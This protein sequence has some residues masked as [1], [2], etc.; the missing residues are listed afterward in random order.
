MPFN[1]ALTLREATKRRVGPHQT[2]FFFV[3]FAYVKEVFLK[4][5]P[6]YAYLEL[7]Y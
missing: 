5:E 7:D 1:A 4:K 2:L 3:S 6:A